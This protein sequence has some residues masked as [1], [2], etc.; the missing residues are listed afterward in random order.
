LADLFPRNRLANNLVNNNEANA[1]YGKEANQRSQ[2]KHDLAVRVAAGHI[3]AARGIM[4]LTSNTHTSI[5]EYS[6]K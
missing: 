6:T 5:Q 4:R 2:T 3:R 1:A